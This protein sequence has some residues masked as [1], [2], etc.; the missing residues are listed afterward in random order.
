MGYRYEKIN[1]KLIL[2]DTCPV[3][4]GDNRL[5]K[6]RITV[7]PV[8]RSGIQTNNFQKSDSLI[9]AGDSIKMPNQ[10]R[11]IPCFHEEETLDGNLGNEI[12]LKLDVKQD[13]EGEEES[14]SEAHAAGEM[15]IL[16]EKRVGNPTGRVEFDLD[17][18]PTGINSGAKVFFRLVEPEVT[19]SESELG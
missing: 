16:E 7:L 12:T 8:P 5:P 15:I 14:F 10:R 3:L 19:Y 17:E 4:E 2:I 6:T 9:T 13:E 11:N 18:H 1:K